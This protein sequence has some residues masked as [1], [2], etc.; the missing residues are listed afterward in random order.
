MLK[1]RFCEDIIKKLLKIDFS[2]WDNFLIKSDM[3]LLYEP[4]NTDILDRIKD[5]M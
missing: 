2:K 1:Y 4:L 3:S 5:R